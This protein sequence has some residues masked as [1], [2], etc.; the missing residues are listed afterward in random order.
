MALH[1]NTCSLVHL[2]HQMLGV[3]F[4]NYITRGAAHAIHHM[5]GDAYNVSYAVWRLQKHTVWRIHYILCSVTHTIQHLHYH[6][7]T[8]IAT[9]SHAL[10]HSHM[11]CNIVTC[12][13]T[14]SHAS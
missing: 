4:I 12:I 3:A 6:I 10:S 1:Q 11:Y 8:C 14:F 7:I 5:Q 2:L 9:L 13:I